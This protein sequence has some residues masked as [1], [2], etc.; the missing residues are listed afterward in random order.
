MRTINYVPVSIENSS[1]L[2]EENII[3]LN[4]EVPASLIN[5]KNYTNPDQLLNYY[6]NFL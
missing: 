4:N 3:H 5:V 6:G 2:L 1:N